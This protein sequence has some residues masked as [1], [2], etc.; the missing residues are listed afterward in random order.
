MSLHKLWIITL[1]PHWISG[2]KYY[3]SNHMYCMM[4]TF[5]SSESFFK[6]NGKLVTPFN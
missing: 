4:F 6:D 1:I 3:C 5:C 2:Y